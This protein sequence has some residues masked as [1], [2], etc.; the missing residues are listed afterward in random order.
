M[1]D[2][3]QPVG[4]FPLPH[5]VLFP[6]A[7]LPLHVFEPRYRALLRDALAGNGRIVMA[8]LKPGYEEDYE[9]SPDVYPTACLGR[10]VEHQPLPDGRSDLILQGESVVRIEEFVSSRP[11]RSARVSVLPVGECFA[12]APGAEERCRELHRLLER[13]CPGCVEALRSLWTRDFDEE[14]SEELL[15]TV[16]MHLPVHVERKLEWLACHGSLERWERMRRTLGDMG[17]FRELRRR[18]LIRYED[19]APEDPSEN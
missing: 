16:A 2:I 5:V 8:V 1:G 13:A 4:V 12:R 17:D 7:S 15:H 10:I 19:L 11:Y 14:C 18:I 9:G 3:R 6:E